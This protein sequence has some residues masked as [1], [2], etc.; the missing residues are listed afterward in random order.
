MINYIR[1]SNF[2]NFGDVTLDLRGKKNKPKKMAFIYG[3]NGAGKTNLLSSVLFLFKS[4]MTLE[5]QAQLEIFRKQLSEGR[6]DTDE[7]QL[8]RIVEIAKS[9]F[10]DLSTVINDAWMIDNDGTM[11][12]EFGF[13]VNNHDGVYFA[14]FAKDKIIEE[15]LT[16]FLKER[17]GSVFHIREEGKKIN[18]NNLVF[19]E[20][21]YSAVLTDLVGQ[22]W[23]KHSFLAIL[24]EELQRKQK[25]YIEKNISTNLLNALDFLFSLSV[26]NLRG[27][28]KTEVLQNLRGGFNSNRQMQ[29]V[30]KRQDKVILL[31]YEEILNDYL[32]SM[33]SDV[34][35]VKYDILEKGDNIH[36][37]LTLQK[38]INGEIRNV[39]A[40]HE[41]TGILRLIH[42]FPYILNCLSGNT[43]VIDELDNGIHDLMISDFVKSLSAAV[44]GQFIASTHNTTLLKK[45]PAEAVYFVVTDATGVA[46][47]V[48][49]LQI[50]ERVQGS[51]NIAKK[52]LEGNYG[53]IPYVGALDFGEIAEELE[54]Y[55]TK[56]SKRQ[57]G[58]QHEKC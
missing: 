33:L 12:L 35:S 2:K 36:Y 43:V 46:K 56:K 44:T 32:T 24:H 4:T 49:L 26:T 53:G 31:G 50:E 3:E 17:T 6:D 47:V 41:S 37:R 18:L 13:N 34:K 55:T 25:L 21:D 11:R 28:D 42:Y 40:T 15:K 22:Y 23:G 58:V 7:K 30:V 20:K 48:S 52:Y 27:E 29:G 19:F 5:N 51:N 10:W 54:E 9:S 16:Y 57:N 39:F 45:L 38:M 8:K 14:E 1:L